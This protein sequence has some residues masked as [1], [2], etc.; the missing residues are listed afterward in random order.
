MPTALVARVRALR[1]LMRFQSRQ[2]QTRFLDE[3]NR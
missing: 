2:G 3:S 1:W